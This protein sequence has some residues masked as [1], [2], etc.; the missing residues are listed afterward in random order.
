[1]FKNLIP[2]LRSSEEYTVSL[3]RAP[4]CLSRREL[5]TNIVHGEIE[6]AIL[7]IILFEGCATIL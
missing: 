6:S 3:V 5:G 4:D 2:E 1:M 7:R